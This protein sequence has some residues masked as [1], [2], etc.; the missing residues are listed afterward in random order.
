MT[1]LE[2]GFI[3]VAELCFTIEHEG[4]NPRVVRRLAAAFS[5]GSSRRN[6]RNGQSK[7]PMK[8]LPA[9]FTTATLSLEFVYTVISPDPG[10]PSG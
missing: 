7:L 9:R 4:S 10:T 2:R 3:M 1:E 8:T 6:Q 5:R